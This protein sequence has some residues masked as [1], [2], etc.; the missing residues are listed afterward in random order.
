VSDKEAPEEKH[1]SGF[2]QERLLEAWLVKNGYHEVD[3]RKGAT[4]LVTVEDD[5]GKQKT[6]TQKRDIFGCID[7]V[8]MGKDI[9]MIQATTHGGSSHRRK[10][11]ENRKWPIHLVRGGVLRISIVTHS[12]TRD[13]NDLRKWLHCWH[14]QDLRYDANFIHERSCFWTE[15]QDIPF[16]IK[17]LEVEKRE[18]S[19]DDKAEAARIVALP[20]EEKEAAI[21]A[22][23]KARKKR[24]KT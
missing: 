16:D 22:L 19:E 14:V 10:K 17:E 21:K 18:V 20:P 23:T 4:G 15:W 1:I 11:V 5:N 24:K 2:Q 7:L 9:W 13:K 6:F 8:A 3:R 12:A